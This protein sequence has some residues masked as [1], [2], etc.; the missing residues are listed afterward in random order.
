MNRPTLASSSAAST[1]SSTQNGAG[2]TSS[3][4]NSRATAVSARSPPES[5]ASACGFLPG[6]RAV[7]SIPVVDRSFGS[8]SE[9]RAN[10]PPNS[11]W[12]RASKATSSAANVVRNWVAIRTSRSAISER[13][14][15]D[16]VAQVLVLGLE[17]LEPVADACGTRRRR[18]GSRRRARGYRRRSDGQAARRRRLAGGRLGGPA[19]DEGLERAPRGPRPRPPSSSR[20]VR[21]PGPSGRRYRRRRRPAAVASAAS[22]EVPQP[23]LARARELDQHLLAQR[24]EVEARLHG[25]D[26]GR[27]RPVV[28]VRAAARA[29]RSRRAPPRRAASRSARSSASSASR[30]SR[31]ARLVG[32][33][34]RRA[35]T[36]TAVRSS[37]RRPL[38]AGERLELARRSRR[39]AARRAPTAASAPARRASASRRARSCA[40]GLG[41]E[42]VAPR[43]QLGQRATPRR[44]SRPARVRRSPPAPSSAAADDAPSVAGPSSAASA[45]TA[46]AASSL[47]PVGLRAVP[48]RLARRRL[49]LPT[50]GAFLLFRPAPGRRRA[51]DSR[52]RA[53]RAPRAPR[54]PRAPRCAAARSASAASSLRAPPPRAPGAPPPPAPPAASRHARSARETAS[55]D[56][57]RRRASTTIQPTRQ[58]RLDAAGR[59]RGPAPRPPAR[60]APVRRRPDRGGSRPA[61][62]R[63]GR[64]P[65]ASSSRRSSDGRP[66]ARRP[67][68]TASIRSRTASWP[69]S[70]PMPRDGRPRPRR[71]RARARPSAASTAARSP[72]STPRSSSTRRPPA[73]RAAFAMPRASSSASRRSS[74]S[75]LAADARERAS[76]P[77][78][79]AP[80]R[81]GVPRPR[82]RAPAAPPRAPRP[83]AASCGLGA[84]QRLADRARAPPRASSGASRPRSRGALR[85]RTAASRRRGAAWPSRPR[86]PA[87][88]RRA[89]RAA[90]S[91]PRAR[92]AARSAPSSARPSA[93]ARSASASCAS[94]AR[95]GSGHRLGE[96]P[97]VRLEV[98]LRGGTL[99]GDPRP[100][101]GRGLQLAG[102]PRLAQARG[103]SVPRARPRAPRDARPR[104]PSV[105]P[106][107]SR[108]RRPRS[109]RARAPR[110]PAPLSAR[111]AS[112]PLLGRR[113]P[114]RGLV[115][116]AMRRDDQR[117]RQLLAR[118]QP[119]R[120]LLGEL[121]QAA[122]LRPELGED[123]VDAREVGLGL[124][125][126]LLGACRRRRSWRRTPGDLLEQGPALLGPQ[127]ERLVDH[128]LAD[129]QERVLGEVRAVEQVDEV[130]QPDALAVE[131]VVVLARA[132]EAAAELDHAV[133]DRQQRVAVVE[134]ER[135][136]GHALRGAPLGARPDHV[137]GLADPERAALLAERP[138]ERVREVRLARAV[139][140]DDGADPR[141]ELDQRA[142]GERLEP[143]DAQA[144]EARRGAHEASS[145]ATSTSRPRSPAPA[146]GLVVGRRRAGRPGRARARWRSTSSAS[147]AADVSAI[148]RDG[149]SPT[150]SVRPL[151]D[152]LD[153][154]LLLVV[155]ARPPRR[156]GRSGRSPVVRCV[157]SWSRLLGL[158][159][160]V[161]ARSAASSSAAIS[162]IQ[163]RAASQPR[164]R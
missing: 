14:R 108:S 41:R 129:E 98:R 82:P 124:G 106:S 144:Q 31:A 163:S 83:P 134:H 3:I 117:R 26:V 113:G 38:P 13:V 164:S 62:G 123:V 77:V 132:V 71:R 118:G 157:C 35:P 4:A 141:A 69:R 80:P 105:P 142:L 64:T 76:R 101:A 102:R 8:V 42:A 27:A 73:R 88:P 85:P 22:A 138:A 67:C 84:G 95:S 127:G 32:R 21:R 5:I 74:A 79:P 135:H 86:R 51:D 56:R 50:G 126:L 130:A 40:A 133:L 151:D 53:P 55:S 137:L 131:Q 162:W 10:P 112:R 161:I 81:P 45:A 136:V 115:P 103:R 43:A 159:S 20:V 91:S 107:T 143:L 24:L 60:A 120:L 47:E 114:R 148:R 139:G 36:A 122:R 33:G 19:R 44:R 156:A 128:A 97:A 28:R 149:P 16:R 96:R 61:A 75:S 58:R 6:G 90:S 54:R 155:R 68:R 145:A 15:S 99:A 147:A 140:P 52:L 18:T 2:R 152:D 72:G 29:P 153:P 119:R 48:G 78:P 160:V 111:S 146:V 158:L 100:V 92:L 30:A 1:S 34:L 59:P 154:E 150:P 25:R 46:R 87:P 116:A 94:V 89:A 65:T 17:R 63:R 57:R 9:S 125:E 11:C 104:A 7:I 12:K 49:E 93:S 109:R 110:A 37:P 66:A 70:P 121:A 39:S 23:D